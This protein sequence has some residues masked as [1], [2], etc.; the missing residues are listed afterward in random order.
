[1]KE[2]SKKIC[3]SYFENTGFVSHNLSFKILNRNEEHYTQWR[4][5]LEIKIL[6][7]LIFSVVCKVYIIKYY[8]LLLYFILP[9]ICLLD[10]I[11]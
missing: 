5:V 3:Y 11:K 10:S 9:N 8:L 7:I 6:F 2:N 1:M 4:L